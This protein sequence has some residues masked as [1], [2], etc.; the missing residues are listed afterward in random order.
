MH[1]FFNETVWIA[2]KIPLKFVNRGLININPALVQIMGYRWPG[3]KPFSEPT[4][5]NVLTHKSVSRP[6]WV[7][8]SAM[9]YLPFFHYIYVATCIH[10]SIYIH[11][12]C[13]LPP[14]CIYL[15]SS[16]SHHSV[17]IHPLSTP[18]SLL[19]TVPPL[20]TPHLSLSI[21]TSIHLSL[22]ITRPKSKSS[23][24]R[25]DTSPYLFYLDVLLCHISRV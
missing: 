11:I 17:N 2:N 21:S 6:Q 24:H 19:I 10:L 4:M 22:P 18:I 3:D 8:L 13:L 16:T 5:V 7:N 25:F 1:F 15:S 20:F 9:L 12:T 23:R 14:L